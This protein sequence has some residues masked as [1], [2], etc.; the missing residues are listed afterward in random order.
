MEPDTANFE[1]LG[2]PMHPGAVAY[3]KSKGL[4]KE[5]AH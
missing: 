3:Y 5:A 1:K 2:A 4:Y